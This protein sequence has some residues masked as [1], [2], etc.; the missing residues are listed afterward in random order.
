[1]RGDT[2][3]IELRLA[4]KVP[5]IVYVDTDESGKVQS[6]AVSLWIEPEDRLN[7]LD[8]RCLF[9]LHVIVNG[10]DENRVRWV[11]RAVKQ[12]GAEKVQ[13]FLIDTTGKG[14]F[15][16]WHAEELP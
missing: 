1:M 10:S 15:T 5:A 8:L 14:E 7:R 6:E 12:A 9:G 3:L 4:G 11:V 16:E 13:A 2:E